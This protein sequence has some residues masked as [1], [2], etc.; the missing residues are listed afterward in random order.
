M[1]N[2][3]DFALEMLDR[4]DKDRT[5][6]N[7]VLPKYQVRVDQKDRGFLQELTYG[8]I[9]WR[10]QY[11]QI[12]DRNLTHGLLSVTTRNALRL[13]LH[14]LFRMRVGQHAAVNET[15]ELIKR[16]EPRA[17]GLVNALLRKAGKSSL[18][19]ELEALTEGL[20]K[21][22]S[23][24]L[25]HSVPAWIIN[26]FA[27][28]LKVDL[29]S[30]RLDDELAALNVPATVSLSVASEETRSKLLE[31]G[32]RPGQRSTVAL[33]VSGDITDFLVPGVRVQDQGSQL[34]A[35]LV[36]QLAN[37]QPTQSA[38]VDLCAGPG[39]K[40]ALIADLAPGHQIICVEPVP[41]RAEL[42][43]KAVT[44]NRAEIVVADG[45]N[46]RPSSE[47]AVC[48]VIV[49]APCSGLGSLRRKPESRWLK[50]EG[51]IPKLATLQ[52]ALLENASRMISVG[53]FVVYSTCTPVLVETNAVIAEFLERNP[54]FELESASTILLGL[55]PDL[56]IDPNRKTVQLWT[57][58]DGTDDMF[59][60]AIRRKS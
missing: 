15:V 58:R 27:V 10:L 37:S 39:G 24:E 19:A 8:T 3:R 31:K 25:K 43:R 50:S 28:S 52:R 36:A 46:F 4:V 22:A 33:E 47:V 32:A 9:R 5:Y 29:D 49:D 17:S 55:S 42:V 45:T 54:E 51:D 20:S 12:I 14:Q 21:I 35:Q 30:E 23:L 16:H 57:S 56:Q 40:A 11:D 53:G 6:L 44:S 48:V 26:Q 2:A 59:I 38:I 41:A 60:A 18:E 13:G 1:S 7:L 34:I